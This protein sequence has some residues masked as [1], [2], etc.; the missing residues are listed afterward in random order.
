MTT[1][2]WLWQMGYVCKRQAGRKRY[3]NNE[4]AMKMEIRGR[5][6]VHK[7]LCVAKNKIQRHRKEKDD[8]DNDDDDHD[9]ENG[10]NG[11]HERSR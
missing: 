10:G 7:E 5:K 3:L 11:S 9:D 4:R 2:E 6:N 8:D 1:G